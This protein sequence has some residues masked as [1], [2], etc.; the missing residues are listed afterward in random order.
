MAFDKTPTAWL[1]GWSEDGTDIT[2]PLATFPELTAAEADAVDGDIRKIVFAIAEK[3]YQAWA[4][5]PVADRPDKLRI[6]RTRTATGTASMV[7]QYAFRFELNVTGQ[8]VED[9]D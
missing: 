2:V 5:M 7:V 6:T 9:E 3:L 8:E 1:E 4:L